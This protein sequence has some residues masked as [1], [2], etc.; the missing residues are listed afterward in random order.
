MTKRTITGGAPVRH[1]PRCLD[2]CAKLQKGDR[3][4]CKLCD[5]RP[6]LRL[7]QHDVADWRDAARDRVIYEDNISHRDV[8]TDDN[9]VVNVDEDGAWVQ[10]W[11]RV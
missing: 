11:V 8:R 6:A 10:V 3:G 7:Q 1:T 5:R 9:C 2:C 4:Y